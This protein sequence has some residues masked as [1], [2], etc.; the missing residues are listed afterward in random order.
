MTLTGL[1]SFSCAAAVSNTRRLAIPYTTGDN[2]GRHRQPAGLMH[3]HGRSGAT[4]PAL[5]ARAGHLA[6]Q[7]ASQHRPPAGRPV[8][9][10]A[11]IHVKLP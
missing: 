8:S 4:R 9:T 7:P 5:I 6:T 1:S 11:C 2:T 3:R 10:E